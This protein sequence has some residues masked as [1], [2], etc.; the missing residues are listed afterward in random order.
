MCGISGTVNGEVRMIV[1]KQ[2][3]RG[4][5]FFAYEMCTRTTLGHNR[6]S[7]IDLSESGNQPMGYGNYSITFNGEIYNYEELKEY[8]PLHNDYGDLLP[9][10][11]TFTFLRYIQKFGIE[12][13]LNDSIGMFAFGLYDKKENKIH[14]IVDR[15]GEKPLYYFHEENK[16]VFASCPQALL[17]L[18]DKWKINESA[19]F[20]FWKLGAVMED[21]IFEGIKRVYASEWVT[22]DINENKITKKKYWEPQYKPNEDLEELIFDAV[23]Y[24]KVSDVPV[25]VFLSGGIDSTLVSSQRF[26]NAIHMDSPELPY[27]R[28]VAEKFKM[29]LKVISPKQTDAVEAMADYVSKC[30]EPSMSALIPYLTAKEASKFCK[31]AISANGAD[32]LFFGYDRTSETVSR[33]QIDHIF[34]YFGANDL[35]ETSIRNGRQFEL[36]TYIEHDLNK[37]LDF[38]SMAHSL[39]V[40]SPFLNHKLVEAALSTPKEKIGRKQIL[41]NILKRYGFTDQFLNRPKQGFSLYQKPYNYDVDGAYKWAIQNGRLMQRN[42]SPR[43][44]QY[45]KAS[46]FSFKIWFETFKEKL[47]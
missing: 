16:F 22:Y 23:N 9:G 40:R 45:L 29:N 20:S 47:A 30:G 33:N 42:Y 11:D 34:R 12:K 32:E 3:F 26:E 18:K 13:A 5:D 2:K 36:Q 28:Q 15:L 25:Y 19:L 46:A 7:I 4:P 1:E 44:L 14:L 6:L 21:S 35:F 37:T 38:A 17:H 10:G 41:K 39:E 27:A 8:L 24:V 43:D 31:V